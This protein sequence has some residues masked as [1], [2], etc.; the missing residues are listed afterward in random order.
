MT[1][2][3]LDAGHGGNDPG[4]NGNG[5]IEKN[6]TLDLTL[7]VAQLLRCDPG[8]DIR[9]TREDDTFIEL[10]ERADI[11]NRAGADYFVSLHH[12]AGGGS[13]FESYVYPGTS[14]SDT[15]QKRHV[16]HSTIMAFLSSYGVSDRGEKEA[17]FAVLRETQMSAVLLENLFLDSSKDTDLLKKPEFLQGLSEAIADGIKAA[18]I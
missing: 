18:V 14:E 12:N 7:R 2:I 4:A 17:N 13:G 8:F 16:V 11:A 3:I 9:L 5:L 6:L 15:G 10:S 1:L